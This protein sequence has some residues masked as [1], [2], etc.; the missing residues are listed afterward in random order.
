M[1]LTRKEKFLRWLRNFLDDFPLHVYSAF[2]IIAAL[3]S[4]AAL[5][6]VIIFLKKQIT[7]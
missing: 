3:L 6:M 7:G 2:L 5:V 4:L 1:K